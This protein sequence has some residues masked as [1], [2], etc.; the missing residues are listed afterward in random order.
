MPSY[1]AKFSWKPVK[2]LPRY[3]DLTVFKMA[4]V[5]YL[6]VALQLQTPCNI[7]R[8]NRRSR[9][10]KIHSAKNNDNLNVNMHA[11]GKIK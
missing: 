3:G 10:N 4:A 7:I 5:Y 2:S 8:S 9:P 1:R 11:D 6:G